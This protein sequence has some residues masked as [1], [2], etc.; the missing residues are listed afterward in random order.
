MLFVSWFVIN[1]YNFMHIWMLALRSTLVK[2][3]FVAFFRYI[4]GIQKSDVMRLMILEH[5]GGVYIDLDVECVKPLRS[6]LNKHKNHT[7]IFDREPE[8]Q[9]QLLHQRSSLLMNSVMMT[10]PQHPFFKYLIERLALSLWESKFKVWG[11]K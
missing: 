3:I 4:L 9:T 7:S 11:G 10:I 1:H 8:L 6:Y 2:I 5:F